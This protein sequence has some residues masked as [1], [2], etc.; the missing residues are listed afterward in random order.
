MILVVG[1]N[2]GFSRMAEACE[3]DDVS[4]A[5]QLMRP[6]G[7]HETHQVILTDSVKNSGS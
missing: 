6:R 3:L 7:Q 1:M 4:R 2:A 5:L